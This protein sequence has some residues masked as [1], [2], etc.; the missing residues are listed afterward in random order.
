VEDRIISSLFALFSFYNIYIILSIIFYLFIFEEDKI[1]KLGGEVIYEKL[2]INFIKISFWMKDKTVW[3]SM[4]GI[5]Q[6]FSKATGYSIILLIVSV[7]IPI[8]NFVVLPI[9]LFLAFCS[10]FFVSYA[11]VLKHEEEVKSKFMIIVR[12]IILA[13]FLSCLIFL[14][15]IY[16]F[17]FNTF[18]GLE[19]EIPIDFKQNLY[20]SACF[21][22]IILVIVLIISTYVGM[23]LILGILPISLIIIF[24]ILIN[25]SKNYSFFRTKIFKSIIF[26]NFILSTLIIPL[27]KI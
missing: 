17:D 8:L 22:S 5:K 23:W 6:V 4:E 9:I 3:E 21:A 24:Y 15:S 2:S 25:L 20:L 14:I 26:I 10:Y 7:F 19:K 27:I 13:V 16:N 12:T 18:I 11:W 1:C